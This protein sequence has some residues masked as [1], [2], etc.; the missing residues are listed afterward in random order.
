MV[1]VFLLEA[2]SVT[3]V[4]VGLR[5]SLTVANLKVKLFH[6]HSPISWHTYNKMNIR[7]NTFD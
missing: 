6:P 5:G 2:A 7:R 3:K 1:S 4:A